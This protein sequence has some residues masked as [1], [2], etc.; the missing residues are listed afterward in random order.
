MP[1]E[2]YAFGPGL[3]VAA[4]PDLTDS[5]DAFAY[6][7]E[8]DGELALIDA[9]AGPGYARMIGHIRTLGFDPGRIRYVV[10]THGHIDH[11]GGLAALVRDHHPKVVAHELDAPAIETGDSNFTAAS[12]YHL[13]M[14]PVAVD[15]PVAGERTELPLGADTLTCIHAPGHTPGSM[16]VVLDRAG[17][18]YLFG[19]DIH[20]PFHPSFRSNL[21]DWRLSMN[22][23][24]QL[25]ADVLA[26]GHYGVIEGSSRV[27]DFIKGFLR[28]FGNTGTC[29]T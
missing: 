23:L 14:T 4:S 11:V 1:A 16:V 5:R 9:G 22:R 21:S 25:E 28:K 6:L 12:W 13:T 26:E 2:P 17:R 8:A 27:A 24:I 15:L 10:A 3:F 29:R 7:V 20:G 18:R 19:Q